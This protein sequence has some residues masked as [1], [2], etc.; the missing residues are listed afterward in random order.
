MMEVKDYLLG[1]PAE[2]IGGWFGELRAYRAEHEFQVKAGLKV[3]YANDDDI[4]VHAN[5]GSS[6]H[7]F[8]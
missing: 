4:C 3:E 7:V 8:H 5:S 6:E 2:E 1:I